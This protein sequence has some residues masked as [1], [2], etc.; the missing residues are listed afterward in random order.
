MASNESFFSRNQDSINAVGHTLNALQ[1]ANIRDNQKKIAKLSLINAALQK[2]NLEIN[3]QKVNLLED[4]KKYFEDKKREEKQN[5]FIKKLMLRTGPELEDLS[6]SINTGKDDKDL[7]EN[8]LDGKFMLRFMKDNRGLIEDINYQ[9]LINDQ[10]KN[11][12][13]FST[14]LNLKSKTFKELVF[15]VLQDNVECLYGLNIFY[16]ANHEGKNLESESLHEASKIIFELHQDP[17]KSAIISE[18]LRIIDKES[19][20]LSGINFEAEFI[21]YAI[22]TTGNI[23]NYQF[24]KEHV[25]DQIESLKN[26]I[27]NNA[28]NELRDYLKSKSVDIP[29]F[30]SHANFT[31][32][33]IEKVLSLTKE[34]SSF[35]EKDNFTDEIGSDDVF[36]PSFFLDHYM[37]FIYKEIHPYFWL[38]IEKVKERLNSNSDNMIE[39][40]KSI[41]GLKITSANLPSKIEYLKKQ[42]KTWEEKYPENHFFK[43]HRVD[44]Q[45][46]S[47]SCFVVT[48]ATGSSNNI[49]V[50][51]FREYRDETLI[52]SFAGR[53]FISIYYRIGP[54][55][56][57]TINSSNTLKNVTLKYFLMPI[58]TLIK[59][60]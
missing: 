50:N 16:E 19:L 4:Q 12:S 2:E 53:I 55:L 54:Y 34:I 20:D 40:L 23:S 3:K 49:I 28:K 35:S 15:Q 1:N 39:N 43:R 10:E 32:T 51:D 31:D 13:K 33:K 56:A 48:A 42:I 37:L 26:Q 21:K 18:S 57:K 25:I 36:G 58:H 8:Y 60:S 9:R 29:S 52:K 6:A 44:S 30:K 38:D 27:Q 24:Y 22:S 11:L 5:A 17:V 47:S 7:Y 59:K 14:E 46:Q 45:N 41:T